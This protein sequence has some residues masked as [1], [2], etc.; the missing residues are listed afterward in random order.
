MSVARLRTLD[1]Y[2]VT[3]LSGPFLF[4]LTAFSLIIVATQILN[5]SK[6]V[7]ENHAPLWAAVEYFL[8]ELPSVV[9]LVIPMAML[10]GVLLALQRL[11]GDSEIIALKAG[12]V[13]VLRSVMP[14]L[15]TGVLASFVSL[16]LQEG[17]V[18]I[19]NGR[20]A[21]LRDEVI[22]HID[23]TNQSPTVVAP[24]P[25]GGRQLTAATA[26]EGSTQSLLN[27]TLIQYSRSGDPQQIVFSKRAHFEAP[28]WTFD[29]ATV[30]RFEGGTI[31]ASSEPR[32]RIDIGEKPSSLLQRLGNPQDMSRAQIADAL[33]NA[34]LNPE[35]FGSYV[36]EFHAKLAR[37][38][39][40]FVFA[41]I[42]IPFGLG[43]V[44]GRG[45]GGTSMGFGLA[46]AIVFVYYVIA[47]VFQSIGSLVPAIAFVC[48]WMP[49]VIFTVIGAMMLR[50]VAAA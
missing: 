30:Y 32:L 23:V 37:P 44:R 28:T 33:R 29:D 16:F 26:F 24:L 49:N 13:S 48:A 46:V 7:S 14:L 18:P 27:V 19:A 11:S 1:R 47:T 43:A 9:V 38:F 21:Y 50:R 45:G 34:Q 22:R 41:L 35:Q 10:L 4:G 25:G 5:I 31:F 2:V 40:C 8:W 6:L 20:A 42:A 12:G 36:A 17:I 15:V 39:A 3:E